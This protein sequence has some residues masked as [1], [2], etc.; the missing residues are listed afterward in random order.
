MEEVAWPIIRESTKFLV[1]TF[2]ESSVLH[3]MMYYTTIHGLYLQAINDALVSDFWGEVEIGAAC[4]EKWE[5][6]KFYN[7]HTKDGS[8]LS[9]QK[10]NESWNIDHLGKS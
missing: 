10:Q 1:S 6:V 9:G 7:L 5:N 3:Y 8:V 4:F 2:Y